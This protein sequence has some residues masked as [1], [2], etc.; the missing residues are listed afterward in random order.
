MRTKTIL[1]VAAALAAGVFTTQAQSNVYSVNIVGY[2]NKE[3]PNNTFVAVA[4]PLD[5]GTN[6]LNST[7]GALANKSVAQFWNGSGFD[8]TTK[9]GGAWAAMDTPVGLGFFV[10]SAGD[11]TNTFV[12]QVVV[13][14]GESVTNSLPAQTF[15]MVGS[16]I[17]YGGD[18]ND[19]NLNLNLPNKSVLQ[20]WTGSGFDSKT[21][22]SGVWPDPNPGLEVGEGFF[23]KSASDFDWIQ[24]LPA[25]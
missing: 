19:A 14:P 15:V 25:N 8:S 16:S 12:G 24:T 21:R 1:S 7:M 4:N 10:K 9:S 3:L 17:P 20:K 18:Y 22:S 2:V 6:D 11:K 13:G 5:D 23:L